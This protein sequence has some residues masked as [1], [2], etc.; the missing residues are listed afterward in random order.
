MNNKFA[1]L[2]CPDNIAY[3]CHQSCM[4][5]PSSVIITIIIMIIIILLAT[6]FLAFLETGACGSSEA[7]PGDEGEVEEEE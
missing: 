4:S 7:A 1:F 6:Y 2:H 5:D 3:Y